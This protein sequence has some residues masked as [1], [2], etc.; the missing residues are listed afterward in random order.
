MKY[1]KAQ[2]AMCV[3]ASIRVVVFFFSHRLCGAMVTPIL[4]DLCR[5]AGSH[6]VALFFMPTYR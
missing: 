5:S 3:N 1:T 4:V 6:S 2:A